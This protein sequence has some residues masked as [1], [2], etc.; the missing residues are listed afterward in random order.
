MFGHPPGV[1][2]KNREARRFECLMTAM[3]GDGEWTFRR[4]LEI[5]DQ[6]GMV[7]LKTK[8]EAPQILGIKMRKATWP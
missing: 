3:Q 7:W 2:Q 4:G 8:E 6:G 5:F 1:P